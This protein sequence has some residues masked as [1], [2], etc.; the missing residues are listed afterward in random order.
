MKRDTTRGAT[1]SWLPRGLAPLGALL[2]LVVL[3]LNL[4]GVVIARAAGYNW[5]TFTDNA[6]LFKQ[7]G[8]ND[9]ATAAQQSGLRVY[10]VTTN[11]KFSSSNAWHSWV[12]DQARHEGDR[13][14]VTIGFLDARGNSHSIY[15]VTGPNTGLTARQAGQGVDSARATFNS[16]GV[17]AGVIQTIHN[18][19]SYGASSP[20]GSGAP[21]N[22]NTGQGTGSVAP[23]SSG[24]QGFSFGWLI[25]VIIVLA[26][27]FVAFRLLRPRRPVVPPYNP[28]LS[29]GPYGNPNNQVGPGGYGNQVGPGGYVNQ[30]GSYVNQPGGYVGPNYGN[31]RSGGLGSG[32]AGGLAGGV[33]G[34]VVGSAIGNELFDHDRD[35]NGNDGNNAGGGNYGGDPNATNTG[36][37]DTQNAQDAQ[38]SWDTSGGGSWGGDSGSGGGDSGGS[39]G[40]DSG[41]GGDG[42][43]GGGDGGSW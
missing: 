26:I 42:G 17:T 41:G 12:T 14:A 20:G 16:S 36:V 18:Y 6:N 25:P 37:T 21:A 31:N 43:G 13:G 40:G 24:S 19:Q 34:G 39:W 15:A 38:G 4:S 27:A 11:Q 29:G 2:V 9:I 28:N 22:S 35:G 8:K 7:A 23:A 3:A 32:L 1:R 5:A 10:I 30:P 33:V